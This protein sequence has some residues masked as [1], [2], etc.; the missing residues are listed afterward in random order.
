M[1]RRRNHASVRWRKRRAGRRL[2]RREHF[3]IREPRRVIDRDMQILPAHL[4]RAAATIA[5]DAMANP[6]DATEPFQ[7]EMQQVADVRPLVALDRAGGS[8]RA[9]RFSPAR[10]QHAR[11]R[12]SRH[13][14]TRR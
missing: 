10:R 7:I 3:S 13:A 12:R 14:A 4:P 8:R 2:V 1:P 9:T 11:D 6:G 5:M